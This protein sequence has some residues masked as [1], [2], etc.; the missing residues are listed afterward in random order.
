MKLRDIH[1]GDVL[2][3][4][5]NN[6]SDA[7]YP[8]MAKRMWPHAD[9]NGN[10][11]VRVYDVDNENETDLS[12]FVV[13]LCSDGTTLWRNES[14]RTCAWWMCSRG[15]IRPNEVIAFKNS[16]ELDELFENM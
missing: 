15:M 4:N 1:K 8:H 14:G 2:I 6:F 3:V 10:I 16:K 11:L 9:E 7:G 5:I 13:K 12:V